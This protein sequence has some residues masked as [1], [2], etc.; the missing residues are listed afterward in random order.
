M[1]IFLT[2]LVGSYL[3]LYMKLLRKPRLHVKLLPQ[4]GL[5]SNNILWVTTQGVSVT[6]SEHGRILRKLLRR[7]DACSCYAW[8]MFYGQGEDVSEKL[9]KNNSWRR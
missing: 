9:Y 5:T 2:I 8:V 6:N 4:K 7:R 1:N 3:L